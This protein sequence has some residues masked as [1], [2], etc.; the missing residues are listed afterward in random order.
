MDPSYMNMQQKQITQSTVC[1][2]MSFWREW[3]L[4]HLGNNNS[5]KQHIITIR[6]NLGDKIKLALGFALCVHTIT[7]RYA[8]TET[9]ERLKRGGLSVES[10]DATSPSSI[11]T[12]PGLVVSRRRLLSQ[13]EGWVIE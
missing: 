11:R 2:L 4:A 1:G 12:S 7:K 10:I 9:S 6:S 5:I 8:H 3:P 13:E